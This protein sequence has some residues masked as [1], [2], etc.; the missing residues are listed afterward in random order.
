MWLSHSSA[1]ESVHFSST[2]ELPLCVCVCLR[3]GGRKGEGDKRERG[4]RR[5][6]ENEIGEVNPRDQ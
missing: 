3:V 5:E 4:G 1:Q 2:A 6:Q